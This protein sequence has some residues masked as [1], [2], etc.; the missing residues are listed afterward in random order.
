[1]SDS[2]IK[3][4]SGPTSSEDE[5]PSHHSKENVSSSDGM[6]DYSPPWSS[7]KED[8]EEEDEDDA[9]ADAEDDSND[10]SNDSDSDSDFALPPNKRAR[11]A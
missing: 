5:L 6:L 4:S 8:L 2:P 3:F 10:D 7:K 11:R 1:M 9:D